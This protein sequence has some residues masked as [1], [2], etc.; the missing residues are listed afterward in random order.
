MVSLS[1]LRAHGKP[2]LLLFMHPGCGPCSALLPE[3]VR[4]RQ[5][6]AATL[7][8][9]ML[10]RGTL[11]VNR[12]AV[13]G[14]DVGTVLL[15]TGE[16]LAAQYQALGTPSAVLVSPSG[17]IASSLAQGAEAIRQLVARARVQPS[18]HGRCEPGFPLPRRL[19]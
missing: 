2:I 18:D 6:H 13:A 12:A 19:A 9:A 5:G 8:I 7:T 15:E 1:D 11:E 3:V 10:S 16:D 4:W 14:H 17:R